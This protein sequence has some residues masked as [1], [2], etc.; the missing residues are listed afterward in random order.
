MV[1]G[2]L[3]Q[4]LG[5]CMGGR[6]RGRKEGQDEPLQQLSPLYSV[7]LG[8]TVQRGP[9]NPPT[10]EHLAWPAA[11]RG[12]LRRRLTP[13]SPLPPGH[14]LHNLGHCLLRAPGSFW[15]A[16]SQCSL[17]L[18]A[19]MSHV[20]PYMERHCVHDQSLY[21][22]GSPTPARGFARSWQAPAPTEL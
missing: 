8:R 17:S 15:H 9:E 21:G 5:D 11:A 4:V 16:A 7:Y 13:P 22:A 2:T 6:T 1:R 10:Q 20:P 3:E 18:T 19:S 14:A 12:A